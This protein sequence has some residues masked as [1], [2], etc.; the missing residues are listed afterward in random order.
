[1]TDVTVVFRTYPKISKQPLFSVV[2]KKDLVCR[3][4][5]SLL[6]GNLQLR[7]YCHILFDSCDD[8][9]V[10]VVER[11]AAAYA[12]VRSVRLERAGNAET[13][14]LQFQIALR[15]DS[16]QFVYFA[17]DDYL[18]RPGALQTMVE[19][20]ARG[21]ERVDFVTPH[22]HFDNYRLD[23]HRRTLPRITFYANRH[24]RTQASTCLTFLARREA[25]VACRRRFM[26]YK[27]GNSDFAIWL[28]VVGGYG[29]IARLAVA[30]DPFMFR[31]KTLLKLVWYG[32]WPM[33]FDQRRLLWGPIPAVGTH[34]QFD[35]VGPGVDWKVVW[36]AAGELCQRT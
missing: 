32:F 5:V 31:A 17:E 29:A 2:D 13:F 20:A 22:D 24:W 21:A 11:A 19:F 15:P 36:D 14:A 9:Y 30:D 18:Y 35:E 3:S 33:G 1:M 26:T 27:K 23:F 28:S 10:K 8:D 12:N 6:A 7:I 34:L 25:L 4:L 16:A